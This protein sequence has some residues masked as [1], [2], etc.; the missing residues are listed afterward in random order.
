MNVVAVNKQAI[1]SASSV[2][3]TEAF[4]QV[5]SKSTEFFL[6]ERRKENERTGLVCTHTHSTNHPLYQTQAQRY[7][8]V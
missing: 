5:P 8:T 3:F 1:Q 7:I 6:F 2:F 4:T